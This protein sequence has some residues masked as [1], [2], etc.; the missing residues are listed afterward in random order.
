MTR[1][2]LALA[3][4]ALAWAAPAAATTITFDAVPTSYTYQGPYVEQGYT[5]TSLGGAYW[6]WPSA[7]ELHFDPGDTSAYDLTYSGGGFA[8]QSVDLSFV[9]SGSAALVEAFDVDDNL[10]GSLTFTF[11]TLGTYSNPFPNLVFGRIRI[12]ETG[13]HFSLDNLV[14]DAAGI[15]E[16]ATW[17]MMIGGIG[18]AGGALRRRRSGSVRFA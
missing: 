3:G 2:Y 18:A 16:P 15:P 9:A 8:V 7:G 13:D 14:V 1:T 4:A 12:T 5:I 17:A 10:I 11:P 6:S